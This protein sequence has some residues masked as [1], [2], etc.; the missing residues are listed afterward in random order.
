MEMNYWT[1]CIQ[2]RVKGKGAV[3]RPRTANSGVV[4]PEEE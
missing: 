1:K 2:N 4:V 3:R